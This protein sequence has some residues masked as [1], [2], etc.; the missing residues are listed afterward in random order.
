MSAKAIAPCDKPRQAYRVSE[1]AEAIGVSAWTVYHWIK[2]DVV[3][4]VKI[5]R[6]KN[7][8]VLIPASEISRLLDEEPGEAAP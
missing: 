8:T 7:A 5:G 6:G 1:F 3:K 2:E 4:A